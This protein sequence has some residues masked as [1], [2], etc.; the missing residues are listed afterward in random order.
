MPKNIDENSREFIVASGF[1]RSFFEQQSD[2]IVPKGIVRM[3][4]EYMKDSYIIST[5]GYHTL[6]V[7]ENGLVCGAGCNRSGQLGLGHNKTCH[8]FTEIPFFKDISVKQISTG[9]S[10]TLVV[11]ENGL[12][13]G[14][15]CNDFGQLGLGH[16]KTCHTFT[17]I[18]FFKDN[19]ISIKQIS[20]GDYHTLVVAEDGLVYGVG[21]N[22]DGQLGFG[23]NNPCHTFTKI[24]FFKDNNI[25]IKQIS[26]GDFHTLVVAENGLV[27]GTGRN[28][29]GQ[30]GLGHNE[31]CHTFTKI[32][33]FKDNDISIKQ[34]STG[35]FHTLVV[36][37]N[38]LVYGVGR[39]DF[40][41]LGLGHNKTCH[42]FTKIPFFKDNNI[43][44]KQIST[45]DFH[46]LVVAKNGLVYGAGYNGDGQLGFGHNNPCHTF[47][48]IPF[49]K[50]NNISV[51]QVFT[52]GFHTL[53]VAENGLVYGVGSNRD[54]QLGLPSKKY[55]C[56]FTLLGSVFSK[57]IDFMP[58]SAKNAIDKKGLMASANN[59]QEEDEDSSSRLSGFG[60]K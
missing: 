54:G 38:G 40:G 52:G 39:N 33:F 45:G 28:D 29:F 51:K 58:Y 21:C 1:K 11:A 8:T 7:A 48:K 18:P 57:D 31:T 26:T 42:T 46:T 4:A 9:G 24:P 43:S 14:A 12:V 3:I 50:N 41:Q 17:K 15:G 5:G 44:I 16:N 22:R 37:E 6:V 27:Y 13:Y 60:F 59:I 36:A 49:F 10:H 19:N 30:L 35:G 55:Y 20:T 34:I 32:P 53:V 23:H 56:T 2:S 25:S 47:T